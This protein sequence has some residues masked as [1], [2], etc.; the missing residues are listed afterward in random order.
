MVRVEVALVISSV[1]ASVYVSSVSTVGTFRVP[2][3]LDCFKL[4]IIGVVKGLLVR[5]C[6]HSGS[7]KRNRSDVNL[8]YKNGNAGTLLILDD[9]G[10]PIITCSLPYLR[11]SF[12]VIPDFTEPF[13]YI[14]Y[15]STNA[16]CVRYVWSWNT[17]RR[18]TMHGRLRAVS[19]FWL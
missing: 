9:V 8:D 13:I 3:L 4:S 18:C 17:F 7:G 5:V 12:H 14:F 10:V 15:H 19:L 11:Q 16:S 2:P 6:S 1:V